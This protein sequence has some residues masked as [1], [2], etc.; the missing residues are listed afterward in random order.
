MSPDF[1]GTASALR[2][3]GAAP[4]RSSDASAL[5]SFAVDRMRQRFNRRQVQAVRLGKMMNRPSR[6]LPAQSFRNS[7]SVAADLS[8][9]DLKVGPTRVSVLRSESSR[10]LDRVI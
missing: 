1:G 5:Q 10:E 9:P 2:K 3:C 6:H 4:I 7:S 8:T